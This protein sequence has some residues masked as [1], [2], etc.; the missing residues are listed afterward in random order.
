M[1]DPAGHGVRARGCPSKVRL[2]T[3]IARP[4]CLPL[5]ILSLTL[6]LSG[7]AGL[8]PQLALPRHSKP[9]TLK[10]AGVLGKAGGSGLE[11]GCRSSAPPP[12]RTRESLPQSAA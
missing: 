5:S 2:C 6:A 8:G 9:F 11:P 7:W 4:G 12:G 10:G 3:G 1:E